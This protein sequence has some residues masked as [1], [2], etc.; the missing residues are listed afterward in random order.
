[1]SST[2]RDE[3]EAIVR[4]LAPRLL[5]TWLTPRDARRVIEHIEALH[6]EPLDIA[7]LQP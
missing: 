4:L 3:S 1:M 6:R 5:G 7:P 2:L